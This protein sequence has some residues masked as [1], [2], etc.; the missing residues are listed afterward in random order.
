MKNRLLTVSITLFAVFFVIA[1]VSF[2]LMN[3]AKPDT[4]TAQTTPA[5]YDPEEYDVSPIIEKIEFLKLNTYDEIKKYADEYPIYIQSSDDKTLFA[6]GEL[7]VED[8]PVK[9]FYRL[10]EDGSISRF[11]GQYSCEIEQLSADA[12]WNV[13][14][15]F[16]FVVAEYFG[17]AYFDHSIYDEY[18]APVDAY[19]EASYELMLNGKAKYNLSIIDESDTYWNI[20]AVIVEQKQVRFEFFR[21]FDLREY[22]DTSPNIDLRPE[23]K[24]GE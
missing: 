1:A 20:S 6:I 21:C 8:R 5:L 12:V 19:D 7:Y 22:N 18:G 2:I 23:E 17:N 10:N 9:L 11:D 16:N 3:N 13:V 24:T 15:Y 4:E 14:S